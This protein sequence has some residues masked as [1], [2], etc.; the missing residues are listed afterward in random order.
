MGIENARP[1]LSAAS[2]RADNI[3]DPTS[4]TIATKKNNIKN[5]LNTHQ[6]L[7]QPFIQR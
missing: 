4:T 3:A 7:I 6:P 5:A 1:N 2:R